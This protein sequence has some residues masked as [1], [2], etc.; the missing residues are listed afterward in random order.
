VF[1][2]IHV[3]PIQVDF[4]K[5]VTHPKQNPKKQE[6]RN[7]KNT[8]F[9]KGYIKF[10]KTNIKSIFILEGYDKIV[11]AKDPNIQIFSIPNVPSCKILSEKKMI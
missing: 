11:N 10:A 4:G 2:K 1:S 3:A 7:L 6:E 9:H 5:V 8:K